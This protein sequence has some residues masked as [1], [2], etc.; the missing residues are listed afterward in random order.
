M[1]NPIILCSSGVTLTRA[2]D[3]L[4]KAPRTACRKMKSSSLVLMQTVPGVCIHNFCDIA[5]SKIVLTQAV[6]A[7]FA[8]DKGHIF[9]CQM[10]GLTWCL[11]CDI[12]FHHG[13]TCEEHT[14]SKRLAAEQRELKKSVRGSW[15]SAVRQ[16]NARNN[17]QFSAVRRKKSAKDN[18]RSSAVRQKKRKRDSAPNV[19]GRQNSHHP[20]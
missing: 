11:N 18:L 19:D 15:S 5:T 13:E 14:A 16:K 20:T 6:G 4:T 8:R 10:C 9:N 3:T 7:F 1:R 12:P 17:L 2:S